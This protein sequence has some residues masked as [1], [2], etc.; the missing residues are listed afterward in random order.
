MK[1]KKNFKK[2]QSKI[3]KTIISKPNIENVP[4]ELDSRFFEIDSNNSTTFDIWIH[5]KSF[6]NKIKLDIP[7]KRTKHFNK[8]YENGKLLNSIKLSSKNITFNFGMPYVKKTKGNILG[9]DIGIKD[10]IYCSNGIKSTSDNHGWTLD[11][12]L[13]KLS[14]KKKGSKGFQRTKSHR[15]NYINWSINKL[16]LSNIKQVNIEDIKNLRYKSGTSRKLSHWTYTDIFNKIKSTCKAYGVQVQ[17]VD[18][19][20][21]SQRC[22]QCGWTLKK[23]RNKKAFCCTACGYKVDAD[24]NASKNLSFDLPPM[25]EERWKHL[26]KKGFYWN[27]SSQEPIVLG[28]QK[29]NFHIFQ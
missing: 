23:N 8:L 9:I 18:P 15:K 12:I 16:N 29:S 4:C 3:D 25:K 13:N 22:S 19:V 6:G 11:K 14:K 20:Y 7:I 26:N 2:L 1:N 24:L 17:K 27:V 21:T 5:L 10:L 28:V